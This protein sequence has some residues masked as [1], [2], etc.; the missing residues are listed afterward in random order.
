MLFLRFQLLIFLLNLNLSRC[1]DK[2]N[3]IISALEK[4][5]LFLEEQYNELNIDG[6]FGYRLLQAYLNGTLEKWAL[7]SGLESEQVRV[8]RLDAK[9]SALI[10]KAK[11]ALEKN[12]PDSYRAF[13]QALSPGFWKIPH[14]WVQNDPPVSF[15]PT[16]GS[17]LDLDTSDSCI[18]ILLGSGA[19][20]TPCL[21]PDNCRSIMIKTHCSGYG[22]SHQLFYFLFAEMKGCS[23]PLFHNAQY[24]KSVFCHLMMQINVE[25]EKQALLGTEGDLFTENILFCGLAGFSDFYKPRWLDI[26]LNWQ[27]RERGCFWMFDSSSPVSEDHHKEARRVKRTEKILEGECASH[28]TAVAVGAIG[29]FLHYGF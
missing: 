7:V 25:A 26:I 20:G 9:V 2:R 19:G 23:D 13:H 21:V 10:E 22:L 6:V 16:N 4:A 14:Q 1:E 12:E 8:R 15:S 5:T 28:N 27:K 18:S 17:C 24:Y 11:R 3:S 29:G